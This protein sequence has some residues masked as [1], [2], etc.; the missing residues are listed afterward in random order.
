MSRKDRQG[1]G[2]KARTDGGLA[3]DLAHTER[4]TMKAN[5]CQ[6]WMGRNGLWIRDANRPRWEIKE[7]I[8]HLALK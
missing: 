8:A 6:V 4:H 1:P 7:V 2:G 3:T 5:I